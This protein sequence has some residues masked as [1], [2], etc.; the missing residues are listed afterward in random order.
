[1]W[2]K[3]EETPP[4]RHAWAEYFLFLD[5]PIV[6][7]ERGAP[8][9]VPPSICGGGSPAGASPWLEHPPDLAQTALWIL[10]RTENEGRDHAVKLCIGKR[11][12]LNWG[13]NHV[14]GDGR[15][16]QPTT[17][18]GQHGLVRFDRLHALHTGRIV[19][20]EVLPPTSS[21]LQHHSLRPPAVA[22]LQG[23]NFC[24]THGCCIFRS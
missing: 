17:G 18:Y 6:F 11:K 13:A 24:R 4:D 7:L 20:R 9:T 8:F 23:S 16:F 22:R 2:P 14:D 21:H 10:H 12:H 5:T 1:M 19:K 15:V 3:D